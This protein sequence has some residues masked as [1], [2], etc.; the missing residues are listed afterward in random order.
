[1]PL[2][3]CNCYCPEVMPLFTVTESTSII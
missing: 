1:M 2:F 3:T